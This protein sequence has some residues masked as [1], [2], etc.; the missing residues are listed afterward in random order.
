MRLYTLETLKQEPRLGQILY[1]GLETRPGFSDEV[2]VVVKLS[3]IESQT[4][5]NLVFSINLEGPL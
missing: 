2:Q 3:A 1:L 5:L 4:P